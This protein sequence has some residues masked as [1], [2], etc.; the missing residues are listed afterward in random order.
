MHIM[1]HYDIH[2]LFSG[3]ISP[4]KWGCCPDFCITDLMFFPWW[5]EAQCNSLRALQSYDICVGGTQHLNKMLPN[6]PVFWCCPI[7]SYLCFMTE[8][9]TG[10]GD[11][12]DLENSG[13][14]TIR[15]LLWGTNLT[16]IF[17]RAFRGLTF[18]AVHSER[19]K[20]TRLH[21]WT[22]AVQTF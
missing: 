4:L 20:E 16:L 18:L 11:N 3:T 12:G 9:P 2:P 10:T 19:K 8:T 5:S 22:Y 6:L 13:L 1:R 15:T 17:Q 14:P 7:Y 21:S